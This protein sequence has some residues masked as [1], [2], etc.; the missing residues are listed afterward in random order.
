MA[1]GAGVAEA[2]A[3]EGDGAPMP[4]LAAGG[5]NPAAAGFVVTDERK[6]PLAE[7]AGPRLAPPGD[8]WP[9]AFELQVR[10]QKLDRFLV[11]LIPV[12]PDIVLH[13]GYE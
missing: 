13:A 6:H 1:A 2:V 3:G 11:H 12:E 7:A 10:E 9:E 4:P 5:A 8:L